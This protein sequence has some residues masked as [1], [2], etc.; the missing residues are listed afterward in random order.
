MELA[1][2]D[3]ALFKAE[4]AAVWT[5]LMNSDRFDGPTGNLCTVAPA[6]APAP[7]A[8]DITPASIGGYAFGGAALLAL[9]GVAAKSRRSGSGGGGEPLLGSLSSDI[10][11]AQTSGGQAASV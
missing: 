2:A 6:P 8:D 1:H 10:D 4:F 7:K 9:A 3:A 5:K 11:R